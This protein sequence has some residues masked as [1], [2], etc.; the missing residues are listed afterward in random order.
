MACETKTPWTITEHPYPVYRQRTTAGGATNQSTGEWVAPTTSSLKICGSIGRGTSKGSTGMRAEDL[1][2]LAGGQF[3][4]GDQYFV[5]HSDCD[6][7]LNDII[8]VYGDAAGTSTDK[9]RVITK[10]KAL[11]TF[12]NI[13]G[14]GQ[15][16][17]LVRM[18]LQ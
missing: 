5:C 2:S 4:T 1:V 18:E 8:E 17:W 3:V 13:M 15:N 12:N 16:F 11:S 10:L 14:Y 9:W 6:V 7:A